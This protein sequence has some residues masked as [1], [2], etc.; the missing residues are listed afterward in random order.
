MTGCAVPVHEARVSL[1]GRATPRGNQNVRQHGGT[2]APRSCA[3]VHRHARV[4]VF[5]HRAALCTGR[6]GGTLS[7]FGRTPSPKEH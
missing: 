7:R 5:V 1:R 2:C 4:R 6:N 3:A